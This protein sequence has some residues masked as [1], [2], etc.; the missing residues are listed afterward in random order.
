[1]CRSVATIMLFSFFFL[2]WK[3]TREDTS[4]RLQ[5]VWMCLLSSCF[6]CPTRSEISNR[7][8]K[9]CGRMERSRKK[10]FNFISSTDMRIMVPATVLPISNNCQDQ[11]GELHIS[12]FSLGTVQY[13]TVV[14]QPKFWVWKISD[15]E[16][17]PPPFE[18][19]FENKTNNRIS[20][21]FG[22][23]LF[24]GPH[25]SWNEGIMTDLKHSLRSIVLLENEDIQHQ[26]HNERISE[27]ST[28]TWREWWKKDNALQPSCKMNPNCYNKI[29]HPTGWR[30]L[31]AV[32]F[33]H[34]LV[35]ENLHQSHV[36]ISCACRW[37]RGKDK[38]V[39]ATATLLDI[40]EIWPKR[41]VTRKCFWMFGGTFLEFH[42]LWK[43]NLIEIASQKP[44]CSARKFQS[45]TEGIDYLRV[46]PRS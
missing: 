12:M 46:A 4:I 45:I 25:I 9:K 43:G 39:S 42:G 7:I 38:A 35:F 34:E 40:L 8:E 11:P 17:P 3:K 18:L 22:I 13:C 37:H 26:E 44:H 1:M 36:R 33:H 23:L 41:S 29:T 27:A 20:I 32:T 19:A 14:L 28:R 6:G 31:I 2:C 10:I 21:L 15:N 16:P 5:S 30:V 24:S